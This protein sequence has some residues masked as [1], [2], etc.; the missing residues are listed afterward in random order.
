MGLSN[1]LLLVGD[2][3]NNL[4]HHLGG[5]GIGADGDFLILLPH[6][7]LRVEGHRDIAFPTRD[8]AA[9]WIIGNRTATGS[10]AATDDKVAIPRI[11]EMEAV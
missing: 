11:A 3:G 5:L 10:R 6:L 9:T 1:P 2:L 8:Y 7:A 4:Q